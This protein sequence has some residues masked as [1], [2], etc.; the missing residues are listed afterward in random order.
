MTTL[1]HTPQ[2]LH[3]IR[4]DMAGNY[5]L[6]NDIDLS[7]WGNWETI[8]SSTNKFTGTFDGDG[9]NVYNMTINAEGIQRIG[10]F[11]YS[12][13]SIIE[14]VGMLNTDVTT[15]TT[16]ASSLIGYA[17]TTMINNC[18]AT[19]SVDGG[20]SNYIGG[21]IGMLASGE[22]TNSYSHINV[23]GG[24]IVGGLI[25]TAGRLSGQIMPAIRNSY[26]TGL[27]MGT[28]ARL[29]GI[30]GHASTIT[31]NTFWDIET[32]EQIE[33]GTD[34]IGK[35][36]AEMKTQSTFVGWDFDETWGM[37]GNYPYLQ[38]FGVPKAPAKV[39]TVE[40]NSHVAPIHSKAETET[41]RPPASETI[42]LNSYVA[43]IHA[44]VET[45]LPI[46]PQSTIVD[47]NSHVKP[48]STSLEIS[49]ASFR[50]VASYTSRIHSSVIAE[51]TAIISHVV[52]VSSFVKAINANVT[53]KGAKVVANTVN[54]SSYVNVINFHVATEIIRSARDH[55]VDVTSYVKQI[56]T[57]VDAITHV[58]IIPTYA[59]ASVQENASTSSC[60]VNPSQVSV[61]ENP[62][63]VEVI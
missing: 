45:I 41:Y 25:A 6:A 57:V 36:T 29:G 55:S 52:D 43:E 21:L 4:N 20:N 38:A 54:V 18:Y 60:S 46:P 61:I 24:N 10:L 58:P 53:T 62:S 22:L 19:G 3:D 27:V 34:A 30:A 12:E 48:I 37:N 35:T 23:S 50:S 39:E 49:R 56:Q 7:N 42:H 11:G 28:G 17:H 59:V 26:S 13:G 16:Y 63:R 40:V 9:F 1:I 51:P 47:V 2:E 33:S 44:N 31:H 5:K 14:N 8:G 15:N 32:S